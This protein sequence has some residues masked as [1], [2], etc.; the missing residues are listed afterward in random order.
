MKLHNDNDKCY[1]LKTF[2]CIRKI[3]KDQRIKLSNPGQ[4]YVDVL[5]IIINHMKNIKLWR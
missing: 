4:N 3:A 2:L 5:V 1:A